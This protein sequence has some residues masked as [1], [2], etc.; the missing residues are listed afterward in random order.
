[1]PV[2]RPTGGSAAA[3]SGTLTYLA[4]DHAFGGNIRPTADNVRSYDTASFRWSQIYAAN[5]TISTSDETQ[6]TAFRSL[7]DIEKEALL[8][9]RQHMGLFQWLGTVAEKGADVASVHAGVPPQTSI[10]EFTNRGLDPWRH[11]WF[12]SDKKTIAVTV[13]EEILCV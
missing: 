4:I 10:A 9:C 2:S 7:T 13:M 1:M 3:G 5:A 8:A 11:A 6:K 12:C